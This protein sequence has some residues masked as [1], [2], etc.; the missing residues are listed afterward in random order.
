MD[1]SVWAFETSGANTWRHRTPARLT[2]Q[3][4]VFGGT[5]YCDIPGTGL[6]AFEADT[7]SVKWT[8][9]DVRGTLI[10]VRNGR[11]IFWQDQTLC[12]VDPER[13]DVLERIA[14][15]GFVGM[16][17]DKFEDGNLYA[18][19]TLGNVAKFIPRN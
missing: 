10:A 12:V 14:L 18:V 6:R 11:L 7:G 19:N 17:T 4:A 15:G 9:P 1:Q 13:G 8:A 16:T 2:V 5:V 3:P